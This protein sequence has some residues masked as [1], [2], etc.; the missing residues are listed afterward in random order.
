MATEKRKKTTSS[1]SSD[2]QTEPLAVGYDGKKSFLLFRRMSDTAEVKHELR[3]TS[4]L[5]GT[6]F[7][8]RSF[9][10]SITEHG[11]EVDT[12]HCA[13]F[14]FSGTEG[15]LF[16][17]FVRETEKGTMLLSARTEDKREWKVVHALSHVRTPGIMVEDHE[18]HGAKE[19]TL[20]LKKK[21][22][23]RAHIY[24]GDHMLKVA[25]ER[26]GAKIA[27]AAAAA[28]ANATATKRAAA[29]KHV[30][31]VAHIADKMGFD[32]VHPPRVPH[33][34]FFD[35]VPFSV[36]GGL[37]FDDSI[38]VFYAAVHT[39]D[40]MRDINLQD[41]KIGEEKL[42]KIGFALFAAHE[43]TR[44]LWQSELPV[45][46]VPLSHGSL[47][48]LGITKD[49]EGAVA[50][51][52][53]AKSKTATK[54][55]KGAFHIYTASGNGELGCMDIPFAALLDMK[56][57]QQTLLRKW[58]GNPILTPTHREWER[59]A[60]FNPTALDLEGK[61][62]LLYRALG[63]DGVSRIGYATSKDGLNIDE[64]FA[65]PVYT[66][67]A[68]F[69]T[70]DDDACAEAAASAL[71]AERHALGV[72]GLIASG[73]SGWGGCED[74][75]VTRIGDRIYMTYVAFNGSWPTRTV[76]TSISVDDFLKRRWRWS[77]PMLMSPPGVGSKSVVILPEKINGKYYV[78]HRIWPNIMIDVVDHLEFGEGKQYLTGQHM[79]CPRK[80]FWDSRKLSVGAA[81]IKTDDGW[82]TI[83][84]AVDRLD[85]A[86]YK[87]GAMLLDGKDPTKVLAR[88]RKP[89]LSPEELYENEGK[90][91]V[92]Y[93]GGAVDLGGTLHVYYGGG[94]K[95][96]AVAQI[97]VTEL[98]D[99]L[100]KDSQPRMHIRPLGH[101]QKS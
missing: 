84:N 41:Q 6:E 70:A 29:G 11:K 4:G 58:Q 27:A 90:F 20:V 83:Y 78:F 81:P 75:K 97:P 85:G 13:G 40:I 45:I 80:S 1:S 100:R 69:E 5:A 16:L 26:Q 71:A 23:P 24:F 2:Y 53:G 15:E 43:P 12:R 101:I 37:T 86:K 88:S 73:G 79:I 74:P 39:V 8:G 7:D 91:G 56:K 18:P 96:S 55:P 25:R 72:A 89:I 60:A 62:H 94:D 68:W 63:P 54:T 46:E 9:A 19:R 50:V 82:L 49:E 35:G 67:Q 92:V 48:V 77:K 21:A 42:L 59:D 64:R 65:A 51:K 76:L 22:A 36:F 28:N 87:I 14:R 66:P 38:I 3:I 99:S 30:L 32:I 98:L 31:H 52:V 95:V 57:R 93:P 17:T 61:V 10:V 47:S 44:L 34:Q 33:W